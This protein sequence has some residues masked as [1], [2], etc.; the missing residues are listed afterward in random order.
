MTC[1]GCICK[2]L[3][4]TQRG[5]QVFKLRNFCNCCRSLCIV[6]RRL[7]WI[8]TVEHSV[9]AQAIAH[10]SSQVELLDLSVASPGA[11]ELVAALYRE[12]SI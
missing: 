9:T 11:E 4:A 12:Y 2:G 7:A 10:I 6:G 3:A 8:S 5:R 1:T